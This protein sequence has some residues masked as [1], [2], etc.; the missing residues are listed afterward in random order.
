M[1]KKILRVLAIVFVLLVLLAIGWVCQAF[2]AWPA[3][4]MWLWVLIPIAVWFSFVL[5][6]RQYITWRARQRLKTKRAVEP[7]VAPDADWV[8]GVRKFLTST[9]STSTSALVKH[10]IHFVL[11]MKGS[12]KS[13]LIDHSDIDPLMGIAMHALN[14]TPSQSCRLGFLTSGVAVEIGSRHVDPVRDAVERDETWER[15]LASIRTEV[16]AEQC[17]SIVVCL[18][19]ATL[20][21]A[22]VT[23]SLNGIELIRSRIYDLMS[24]AK[25]RLP[26]HIVLTHLDHLDSCQALLNKL[27]AR[28]LAQPAGSLLSLD[29]TSPIQ[30]C[31]EAFAEIVRYVPWLGTR[32]D[33][34][35]RQ[36]STA[37]LMASRELN[38][39]QNDVED[40]VSAL[41]S[42]STYREAPIFRGLF[43][44]GLSQGGDGEGTAGKVKAKLAFGGGLFEAVLKSDRAFQPLMSVERT[45][46]RR[47]AFAWAGFFATVTICCVWMLA[48]FNQQL[49]QF[50]GAS[51]LKVNHVKSSDPLNTR[52]STLLASTPQVDWIVSHDDS[53]WSYLLPY[54]SSLRPLTDYLKTNFVGNFRRYQDEIWDPRFWE[55][56]ERVSQQDH[57]LV[58]DSLDYQAYRLKQL[59]GIL[60]GMGLSWVLNVPHDTVKNFSVLTPELSEEQ[61]GK[62]AQLESFYNYWDDKDRIVERIKDAKNTLKRLAERDK[63]LF[64]L[65]AWANQLPSVSS[66]NLTDFWQQSA[67]PTET[68][69]PAAYTQKGQQAIEQLLNRLRAVE[70]LN[71]IYEPKREVFYKNYHLKREVSW[72]HFTN[73]FSQGRD[74]LR[75]ERAWLETLSTLNNFQSPYRQVEK[76][77]LSE[78]PVGGAFSR[79]D[80]VATIAMLK[81]TR[82]LSQSRSVLTDVAGAIATIESSVSLAKNRAIGSASS[83]LS[84]DQKNIE[85]A[86]K[87]YAL[88]DDAF[89]KAVGEALTSPSKAAAIAA[90]YS[91][92]GRDATVKDSSL[93]NAANALQR[94][95]VSLGGKVQ[96]FNEPAWKLVQGELALTTHYAYRQAA[97]SLQR[98]WVTDVLGPE[99]LVVTDVDAF[100]KVFGDQGVMWQYLNTTAKPFLDQNATGYSPVVVDDWQ[101]A[102]NSSFIGFLNGAAAE[103]RAREAGVKRREI[104]QK[105]NESRGGNRLK[106]IDARLQEIDQNQAKFAQTVFKLDIAAQPVHANQSA[107]IQPYGVA[108]NVN[109]AQA[110]QR[111]TQLNYSGAQTFTWT[112]STCGDTELQIFVENMTLSIRWAGDLGFGEFLK[113]FRNGLARF[114]PEDFPLQSERIKQLGI[115]NISVIFEIKGGDA[116]LSAVRK[117]QAETA[118]RT[119]LVEQRRVREK[120]LAEEQQKGLTTQLAKLSNVGPQSIVPKQAA[121]CTF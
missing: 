120:V 53:K 34:E 86:H 71:A 118:E 115:S 57:A 29:Q 56:F 11:G 51:Q 95:E 103:K 76:V 112:A 50:D 32:A 39:L 59:E 45:R 44:S 100:S 81:A 88:Y 116:A 4:S 91:A 52:V 3:G 21:D 8:R 9:D 25:R 61:M 33:Q 121:V 109:C 114:A 17:T 42:L 55:L 85:N 58:A 108:L 96:P 43:L 14:D 68:F 12:G 110:P 92:V 111:L 18:S 65:I 89:A 93:R 64:W 72:R 78:F 7:H 31:R 105:L 49:Q 63:S 10:P 82:E 107:K 113:T 62:L 41:F 84:Q 67:A 101:L 38:S 79:P 117:S 83:G 90:D 1:L 46:E 94:L 2:F 69:V 6:R 48:G 22:S 77:L 106:E 20:G 30:H 104:T 36:A 13:T 37:A 47:T 80:W 66:V 35:G 98:A 16:T 23:N 28:L 75:S 102:W 87:L 27:P 5:L 74:L 73:Q 97:C 40:V 24:I 70:V 119:T 60:S 54:S 99:K 15:L 19:V 26:V